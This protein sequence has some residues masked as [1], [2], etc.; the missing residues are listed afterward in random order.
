MR[1]RCKIELVA[2]VLS[3]SLKAEKKTRIMN[4]GNLNSKQLNS[5]L[6]MLI[7]AGLLRFESVSDSYFI[8]A[9]GR[10][11]LDIFTSYR[12]FL[13]ESEEKL[14]VVKSKKIQLEHMCAPLDLSGCLKNSLHEEI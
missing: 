8:T 13:L 6:R 3:A 14:R 5:Y 7:L 2:D 4:Y 12:Q 11:F 9:R 10:L 1:Y